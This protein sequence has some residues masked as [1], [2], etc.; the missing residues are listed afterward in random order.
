MAQQAFGSE[1]ALAVY[2]FYITFVSGIYL[3]RVLSKRRYGISVPDK[4]GGRDWDS[5]VLSCFLAQVLFL[6]EQ[7][8][9]VGWVPIGPA[10]DNRLGFLW[11]PITAL[12]I[13]HI[14]RLLRQSRRTQHS[15]A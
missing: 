12:M 10:S 15:G 9:K 7:A 13:Y 2:A 6:W 8:D 14:A 3:G 4:S 11:L 1:A 5:F